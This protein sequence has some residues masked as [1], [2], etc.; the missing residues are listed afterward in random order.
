[1]SEI[2]TPGSEI[3]TVVSEEDTLVSDLKLL[4]SNNWGVKSKKN[5]N[6]A[7]FIKPY[8]SLVHL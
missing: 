1:M 3:Y 4:N 6:N 2:D 8:R 7:H 5:T